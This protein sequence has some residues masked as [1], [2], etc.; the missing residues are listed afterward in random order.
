MHQLA[1]KFTTTYCPR[2]DDSVTVFPSRSGPLT[3]G[4]RRP[5]S[6]LSALPDSADLR[7]ASST[8]NSATTTPMVIATHRSVCGRRATAACGADGVGVEAGV[9]VEVVDAVVT[10]Q[11]R[12]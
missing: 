4:A 12:R 7:V 1:K 3:S 8:T 11:P 2:N 10:A 5:R 6:G 9:G